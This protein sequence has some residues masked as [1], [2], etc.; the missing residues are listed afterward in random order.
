MFEYHSTQ[1][2]DVSESGQYT[3]KRHKLQRIYATSVYIQIKYII[4]IKLDNLIHDIT[5]FIISKIGSI[6][7][8]DDY[9]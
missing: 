1:I 6:G 8:L 2:A 5:N 3:D 4:R 7:A 9:F